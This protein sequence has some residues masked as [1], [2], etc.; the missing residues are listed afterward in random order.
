MKGVGMQRRYTT[1]RTENVGKIN[2][3]SDPDNFKMLEPRNMDPSGA[4][5]PVLTVIR[6]HLSLSS[7]VV[8]SPPYTALETD[9][10]M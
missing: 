2:I 8:N 7:N 4:A 9:V 5:P 10:G 6:N 1:S 3:K